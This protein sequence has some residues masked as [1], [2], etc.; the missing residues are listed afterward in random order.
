MALLCV[1]DGGGVETLA[2]SEQA[3]Y[4]FTTESVHFLDQELAS[5]RV[6]K[7]RT[8]ISDGHARVDP[9]PRASLHKP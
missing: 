2:N 7:A 9:T 3:G 5:L 8:A 6:C 4:D 1:I